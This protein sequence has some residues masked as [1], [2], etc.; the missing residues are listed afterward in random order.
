[1]GGDDDAV[2]SRGKRGVERVGVH[3]V[4]LEP[5]DTAVLRI[6]G[7]VSEQEVS[8]IFDVFDGFA[9]GPQRA[10]LLIDLER[11]GYVT[12]GARR[13]T[14]TRQLPPAYG[15]LVLFGGTFQQQ[16]MAK[17]ATTAAW[18][19]REQKLGKPRPV[20]VSDEAAARAWVSARRA[21]R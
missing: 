21:G 10:Y 4:E 18:L 8:A 15:G 16:L 12:P 17:M 20:C 6:V 2:W 13:V 3:V 9:V 11:V 19:L 1:M 14:G 5:P 7:E